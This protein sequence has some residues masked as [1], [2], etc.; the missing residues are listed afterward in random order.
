MSKIFSAFSSS[1]SVVPSQSVVSGVVSSSAICST[2]RS[3]TLSQRSGFV[4]LL[5]LCLYAYLGPMLLDGDA[6]SQNL[7]AILMAPN[8]E[9]WLGTDHFGRNMWIRLADALQLSLMMA[10]VCVL[11]SSVIGVTLGVLAATS[12]P[13][14][15]RALDGVVSMILALPGLVLVLIFAAIVPGSFLIL[16]VAISLIQWIEYFRVTRAITQRLVSSPEVQSSK[17]MGFDGWYLF[18]RHYWPAI[19]PQLFTL[20]AFGAANAVL[21]MASLGFV[22]VGIQPPT[23]ELGQMIVELFPH[24][25]EAPWLLAQPLGLLALLVLAC[26]LMAQG[27]K[28]GGDKGVTQ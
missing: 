5:L 18:R 13:W 27:H 7:S 1:R 25:S 16:Y 24:Y 2:I 6:H 3:L 17:L 14:L 15:D 22:H 19:F 20:A 10:A 8:A 11:T 9:Y 26:H 23:A 28:E 12:S 21:M 4:I